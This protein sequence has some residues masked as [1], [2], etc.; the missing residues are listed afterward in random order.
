[1]KRS[2]VV[3]VLGMAMLFSGVF[4]AQIDPGDCKVSMLKEAFQ[5]FGS[6]LEKSYMDR[7]WVGNTGPSSTG[8]P[9]AIK[10]KDGSSYSLD[11][12]GKYDPKNPVNAKVQCYDG[13]WRVYWMEYSILKKEVVQEG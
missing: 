2:L 7:E 8:Y 11:P 5:G 9:W 10:M 4:C 1:M 12:P 6:M 13:A 3:S